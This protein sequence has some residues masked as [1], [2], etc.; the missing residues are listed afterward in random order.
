ML[1]PRVRTAWK[2]VRRLRY[3]IRCSFPSVAAI[4][5]MP[6]ILHPSRKLYNPAKLTC[7]VSTGLLTV[8]DLVNH[9]QLLTAN[10]APHVRKNLRFVDSDS[11]SGSDGDA[12]APPLRTGRPRSTHVKLRSRIKGVRS[13]PPGVDTDKLS[14]PPMCRN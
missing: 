3:D 9:R 14:A 11:S 6:S 13:M 10:K 8:G 2:F 4:L 5:D 1:Q 12:F 7:L